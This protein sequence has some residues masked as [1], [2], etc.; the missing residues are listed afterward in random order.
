MSEA[1]FRIAKTAGEM[2]KAQKVRA[3]VFQKEQ[4]I[5]SKLDFDGKDNEAKHALVVSGKQ[6]IGTARIR[7]FGKKAKLERIAVLKKYR[8]KGIGKKLMQFLIG[9]CK[10]RKM[11]QVFF[12][13][14]YYL[15]GFYEKLG[16]RQK[17]RP[18]QEVGIKHCKMAMKL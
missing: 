16:F 7:F 15:K 1:K 3:I 13:A 17:G 4:G 9:Y 12:D 8:R 5:S 6:V 14:Q 2:K 18:F 11:R 10:K